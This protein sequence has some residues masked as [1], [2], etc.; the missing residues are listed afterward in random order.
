MSMTLARLTVR[1]AS[2]A[3]IPALL[4]IEEQSFLTDRLSP[5]GFR[6]LLTRAR[7]DCLIAPSENGPGPGAIAGYAATLYRR[8]AKV[9]RLHSLAVAAAA[10]GH[11]VGAVLL[12]AAEQAARRRGASVLRLAVR[13]DN[14][15]AIALYRS[16]AYSEL[17]TAFAYYSDGMS[18][19]TME[20]VLAVA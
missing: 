15:A 1:P 3:D 11:G 4:A 14:F 18:A 5:R 9:A 13:A 19:L 2:L 17:G 8:T 20:K 12:A 6:Y 7:A 16:H 10:R